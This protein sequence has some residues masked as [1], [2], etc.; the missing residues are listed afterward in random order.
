MAT[1]AAATDMIT[2]RPRTPNDQY[3]CLSKV[4]MENIKK[5][6]D[7][8]PHF[9]LQIPHYVKPGTHRFMDRYATNTSQY[10][11][12]GQP[13]SHPHCWLDD[14][15]QRFPPAQHN[16]ARLGASLRWGP[17]KQ[18]YR[19]ASHFDGEDVYRYLNIDMYKRHPTN[20]IGPVIQKHGR[21]AESYYHQLY[22]VTETWMGS[23]H[24]LNQTDVLQGIRPKPTA[25][26]EQMAE[27]EK[28]KTLARKDKWPSYSEYTDRF[29][30]HTR[31]LPR[32]NRKTSCV[33]SPAL[34]ATGQHPTH[35]ERYA[36]Y[37]RL[38]IPTGWSYDYLKHLNTSTP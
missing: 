17:E 9:F 1:D 32:I 22:P 38:N 4:Q 28:Y 6:S 15:W 12:R 35:G 31:E 3:T 26:Y 7:S 13:R 14:Q 21:P 34:M 16:T 2:K 18:G 30:V 24:K 33:E 20:M 36:Q 19:T 29:T 10:L 37:S 25:A 27:E 11:F 23:S 5:K 8:S